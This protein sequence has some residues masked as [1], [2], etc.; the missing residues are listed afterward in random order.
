MLIYK[1]QQCSEVAVV[2]GD[3]VYCAACS[4]IITKT[5]ADH[6]ELVNSCNWL[7]DVMDRDSEIWITIRK[8]EGSSE[9][10]KKFSALIEQE[11]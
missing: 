9:W 3:Y 1:C 2:M 4:Y 5:E 11:G 6:D 8:H 10:V 7:I